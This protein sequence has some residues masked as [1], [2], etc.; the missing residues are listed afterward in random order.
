MV[1]LLYVERN[2]AVS[3]LELNFSKYCN[4]VQYKLGYTAPSGLK[5]YQVLQCSI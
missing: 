1:V 3:I 2:Y 5:C 4:T